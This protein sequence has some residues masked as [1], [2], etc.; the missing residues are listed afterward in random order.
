MVGVSLPRSG[1]YYLEMLLRAVF[2][3]GNSGY[4]A[5]RRDC[6]GAVICERPGDVPFFLRK[7]H[8]QDGEM[9]A[10]RTD[11]VYLIRHRSP[12]PR[13]LSEIERQVKLGNY[14]LRLYD[15]VFAAKWLDREGRVRRVV[16]PQMA[17]AAAGGRDRLTL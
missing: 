7:S 12:W 5:G 17:G 9:P 16:L 10:N 15:C 6:C 3:A 13:L 14:K 1:H 2:G 11:V 8:D 4:C